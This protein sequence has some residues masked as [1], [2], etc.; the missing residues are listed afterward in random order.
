[1]PHRIPLYRSIAAR[2]KAARYEAERLLD[3]KSRELFAKKREAEEVALELKNTAALFSEV[4]AATPDGLLAFDAGY[5]V[6]VANHAA[7]EFFGAD[8]IE[9]AGVSLNDLI[10][11]LADAI[12]KRQSDDF[13]FPHLFGRTGDSVRPVDVRGRIRPI[14]DATHGVLS[15][16]D[17]SDRLKTEKEDRLRRAKI[18]E[19]RRLEAIG[20]LSA[21]ISHEIN[22]PIQFIGDNLEYLRGAVGTLLDARQ[23]YHDLFV[24]AKQNDLLPDHTAQLETQKGT[25]EFES[26]RK[27]IM[28]AVTESQDG[29]TQVCEINAVMREFARADTVKPTDVDVNQLVKSAATICRNQTKRVADVVL[30][31]DQ[32]LPA[33]ACHRSQLQQAIVNLVL[34]AAHACQDAAPTGRGRIRLMTRQRENSISISVSDTGSGVP[35]LIRNKIFDPF[36]TTK[37]LGKGTGQGLALVKEFIATNHGGEIL[38]EEDPDYATT[39][40]IVVPRH[41]RQLSETSADVAVA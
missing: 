32:T 20:T 9:L 17:I 30:D 38:L 15:F 23:K 22:T 12:K 29:I 34:N 7:C 26:I 4:L 39:F 19:A 13:S 35:G 24:A 8:E 10:D 5:H 2:E 1:M 28:S 25:T 16:H 31:L 27:E 18:D 14:G 40:T 3:V 21:G 11:G 36:F 33:L 6:T 37:E 41:T